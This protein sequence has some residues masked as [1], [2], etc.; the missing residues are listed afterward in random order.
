VAEQDNSVPSK[1]QLSL[2][3]KYMDKI[4]PVRKWDARCVKSLPFPDRVCLS[5]PQ[6]GPQPLPNRPTHKATTIIFE[7]SL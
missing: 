7:E 4:Q 6:A 3:A 2:N 5:C 1:F